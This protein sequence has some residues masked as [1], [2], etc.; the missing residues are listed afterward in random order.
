MTKISN[1][2]LD[3]KHFSST[4][5]ILFLKQ[6]KLLFFISIVTTLIVY[7]GKLTNICFGVDSEIHISTNRYL[8]WMEIGRFGLVCLQKLWTNILPNKELFNPCLAVFFGC[9]FLF[10]GTLLWCFVIDMLSNNSVKNFCYIPFAVLFIS[11][12]VWVEQIYF[13]CQSAECLFIVFLSPVVVYLTFKGIC[14]RNLK[15]TI[16]GFILAIFCVS[17]YQGIVMLIFCSIFATFL[18]FKENSNLEKNEYT[19]ICIS[20]LLLMVGIVVVYGILDK[21]IQ[22]IF[23]VEQSNYLV[24]QLGDENRSI[25]RQILKLGLYFY[26]L[27]FGNFQ[28]INN[29]L[30]PFLVKFARTGWTAIKG[31]HEQNLMANIIYFPFFIVF[32]VKVFKNK[33][34][35]FLYAMSALSIIFCILAFPILGGG[36]VP[37]RSQYVLP[38]AIS[39]IFLY[40]TNSFEKSKYQAVYKICMFLFIICGARQVL[41]SSMLNYCDV[42]RY[43]SDCRLC[44]EISEK[45]NTVCDDSKIPVFFYGVHHPE[46][47][48]NYVKGEVCGHSPFEW[49]DEKE[50]FDCTVRA[51]AFLKSQGYNYLPANE[52]SI[53]KKARKAAENMPDFPAQ[54]CA[55]NLGDVIVIRLSESLYISE[56]KN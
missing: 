37:L 33:K 30:D 56:Q 2:Y 13:V 41:I 17:I 20:L 3:K 31:M 43:K 44:S 18:F 49:V 6:N 52:K 25:F 9:T 12:Q 4:E 21:C 1:T 48:S 11:H 35:S 14:T 27:F 50:F 54:G 15:K 34:I 45:I 42:M 36:G 5:F 28:P 40:V 8:N 22:L 10:F 32:Y 47:T 38:F 46:T 7:I 53:A 26:S 51:V 39:F 16:S 29:I 55:K 24:G 19:K 23:H